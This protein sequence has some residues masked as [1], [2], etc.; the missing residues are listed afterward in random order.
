MKIFEFQFRFY[1]MLVTKRM[2]R[3]YL[4][5][6]RSR[7]LMHIYVTWLQWI[8]Q[9]S[10]WPFWITICFKN[11]THNP[12]KPLLTHHQQDLVTFISGNFAR[13]TSITQTS[14]KISYIILHSNLQG[15][16]QFTNIIK[17]LRY[18]SGTHPP[19]SHNDIIT[20]KWF[21]HHWPCMRG[22]NQSL[23]DTLTKNQ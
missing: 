9:W 13:I 23:V 10:Y 2:T 17:Y 8:I 19:V 11:I 16:D 7:L 3:Q 1:C 18:V 22:I 15:N 4:I 20:W 14:L 21:P 12:W 6:W 5:Q